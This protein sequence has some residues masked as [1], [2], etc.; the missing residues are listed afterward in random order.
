MLC[1][2]HTLVALHG[3]AAGLST[4]L[5]KG[6][7]GVDNIVYVQDAGGDHLIG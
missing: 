6:G 2:A 3:G 4:L 5:V 1:L 7:G